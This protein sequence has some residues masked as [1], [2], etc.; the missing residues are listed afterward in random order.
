MITKLIFIQLH[1]INTYKMATY[2]ITLRTCFW[3]S[4]NVKNAQ[5]GCIYFTRWLV[6]NCIGDL[7]TILKEW[8]KCKKKDN[9]LQHSWG[10][11]CHKSHMMASLEPQAEDGKPEGSHATRFCLYHRLQMFFSCSSSWS[12]LQCCRDYDHLPAMNSLSY[13][14]VQIVVGIQS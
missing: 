7:F 5:M 13:K 8:P 4:K 11:C 12:R 6:H 14:S 10:L 3:W 1:H 2:F 9:S